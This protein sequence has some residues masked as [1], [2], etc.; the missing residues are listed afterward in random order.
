MKLLDIV[1]RLP[2]PDGAVVVVQDCTIYGT[3]IL[4]YCITDQVVQ[5]Q[6]F[7]QTRSNGWATCSPVKW[8]QSELADDHDEAIITHADWLEAQEPAEQKE[9]EPGFYWVRVLSGSDWVI[10]WWDCHCFSGS[11]GEE[12]GPAE[13]EIDERRIVRQP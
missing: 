11:S 6:Y 3:G 7:G 12:Y 5:I 13:V 8:S 10:C 1:K 2:W 9:R 4:K